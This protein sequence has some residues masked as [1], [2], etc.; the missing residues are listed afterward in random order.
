M[1]ILQNAKFTV[2]LEGRQSKIRSRFG[3]GLDL[4]RSKESLIENFGTMLNVAT[5]NPQ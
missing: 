2:L 5:R 3:H 1:G 4:H